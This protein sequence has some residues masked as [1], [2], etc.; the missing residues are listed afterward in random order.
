MREEKEDVSFLKNWELALYDFP[1]IL[2]VRLGSQIQNRYGVGKRNHTSCGGN[3]P[4]FC[5]CLS[6]A[7]VTMG[8]SSPLLFALSL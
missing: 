1:C 5:T 4:R 8:T 6:P 3:G 7:T 2:L